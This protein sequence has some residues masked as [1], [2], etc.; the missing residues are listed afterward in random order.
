MTFILIIAILYFWI[1]LL[2]TI[3]TYAYRYLY[4]SISQEHQ[5]WYNVIFGL[6]TWPTWMYRFVKLYLELK[7][8][9]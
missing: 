4:G 3:Y 2:W 9:K 6:L 7:N 8:R 1:G 5:K